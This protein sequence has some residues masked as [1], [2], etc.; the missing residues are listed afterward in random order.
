[1]NGLVFK[2]EINVFFGMEVGI[3][4]NGI[5]CCIV[6]GVWEE[7]FDVFE[8]MVWYV[9]ESGVCIGEKVFFEVVFGYRY[10]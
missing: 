8:Y 1:M 2:I 10:G 3:I 7:F 4:D 6:Y 5:V 9:S